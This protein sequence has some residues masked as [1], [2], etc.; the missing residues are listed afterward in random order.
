MLAY[1]ASLLNIDLVILDPLP[2]APA[3]QV[4]NP[5]A[6]PNP[7]PNPTPHVDGSFSD[8][9][10]ISQLASQVDILTVE[11]EHVNVDALEEAQKIQKVDVQ[12]APSTLRAIQDK[13][14]Q[15]EWLSRHSIPVAPYLIVEGG[16]A[17]V[18][19]VG[20][21]LG[22]PFMLKSRTLAY[23]GRGNYV[24]KSAEDTKSGLEALGAGPNID[25]SSR[26]TLYAE[27][28][29]PFDKEIAVM[30]VR[31]KNGE[32]RSYPPVETVHRDSICH[33]VFAPLRAS[34]AKVRGFLSYRRTVYLLF[35]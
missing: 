18:K 7:N 15:K 6:H 26:R 1:P 20:E 2:N 5:L 30:V 27:K 32:V 16:E 4:L 10:A 34:D 31:G 25:S 3:K 11:I 29:I 14:L 12:P 28:W 35:V 22:Y 13:Y 8:S 23:D 17:G 9:K 19:G 33:L 24:V 21:K